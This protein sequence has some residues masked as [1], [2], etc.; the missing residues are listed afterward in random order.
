M[1]NIELLFEDNN[2]SKIN[3]LKK[4]DKQFKLVTNGHNKYWQYTNAK[5][6]FSGTSIK[7]LIKFFNYVNDNDKFYLPILIQLNTVTFDDKLVYIILECILYY[8]IL[9]NRR[10]II[11]FTPEKY[12]STDGISF[13]P[14]N[15]INK[16]YWEF[17]QKF[18]YDCQKH[19]YRELIK[20]SDIKTTYLTSISKKIYMFLSKLGI[21]TDTIDKLCESIIEIVGNSI[22]HGRSDCLIDI[23]VTEEKYKKRNDTE[24]SF[25]YGIN[26]VVLDFSE[27]P[28]N[29]KIKTKLANTALLNERYIKVNEAKQNHSKYFN[30]DYTEDDFYTIASF[31]HKIS[32]SIDKKNTGGVGLTQLIKSLEE[33][34]SGHLCYMLSGKRA[35]NFQKE[36]LQYDSEYYIGFNKENDFYE[37]IPDKTVFANSDT[38]FPGTAYNLNFAI[39]KGDLHHG[40]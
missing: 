5:R 26:V 23:D 31:Q 12:I 37:H 28:F 7:S 40:K 22:E 32:G 17:F 19:H 10:I 25:Y 29:K 14:I 16:N 38:F 33:K 9:N 3:S 1:K 18:N 36:Y 35:L 15:Y 2:K 8:M 4:V 11:N 21:E 20:Y 39:K 27:V 6:N 30:N 13:S 34:S 24:D